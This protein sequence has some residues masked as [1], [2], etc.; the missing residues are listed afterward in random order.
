MNQEKTRRRLFPVTAILL[1]VAASAPAQ[2]QGRQVTGDWTQWGGPNRNF[3][4]PATGLAATWPEAGP[5]RLWAREL[6]EGFS[7][8]AIEGGRLFTMYRRGLQDVVIA[9]DAAT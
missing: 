6:G 4:S 8:I 1:L 3:K 7:G 9:M 2:S 5:R